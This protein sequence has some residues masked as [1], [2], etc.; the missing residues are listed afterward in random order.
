MDGLGLCKEKG[1]LLG[2]GLENRGVRAME[3]YDDEVHDEIGY[4]P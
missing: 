3:T 4:S 2:G 1:E